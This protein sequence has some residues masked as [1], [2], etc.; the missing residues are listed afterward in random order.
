M[1]RTSTAN[2]LT[3]PVLSDVTPIQAVCDA[4]ANTNAVRPPF[5][6]RTRQDHVEALYRSHHAS[7][8]E[9]AYHRLDSMADAEDAAQEAF[10]VLLA[11]PGRSASA[12]TLRAIV[13]DVCKSRE[14]AVSGDE[15]YVE[16]DDEV[17]DTAALW[18][19]AALGG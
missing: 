9:L 1:S 14:A 17:G 8:R 11:S 18:L 13:R 16:D 3:S 5:P 6:L 4:P 10:L 19:Q 12:S 7:L 2:V 15:P